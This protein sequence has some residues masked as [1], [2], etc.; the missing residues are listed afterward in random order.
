MLGR[1]QGV[2][3]RDLRMVRRFL[4]VSGFVMD[5]GFAMMLG[6]VFVVIGGVLMVFVNLVAAHRFLPG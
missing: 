4:V 5:G 3:M 2:P 6:C 1:M